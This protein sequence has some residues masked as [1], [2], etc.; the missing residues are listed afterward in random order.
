LASL[1]ASRCLRLGIAY[2]ELSKEPPPEG[3][4][5]EPPL[6]AVGRG[7]GALCLGLGLAGAGTGSTLGV[8]C[9]VTLGASA[10]EAFSASGWVAAA[11]VEPADAGALGATALRDGWAAIASGTVPAIGDS[12]CSPPGIAAS[13]ENARSAEEA[14]PC[15]ALG[16][17]SRPIAKKQANTATRPQAAPATDP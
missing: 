2:L 4:E 1:R 9:V 11:A 15:G 13:F 10:R 8:A 12:P 7:A 3:E 14:S 5:C 6:E 16:E 17:L